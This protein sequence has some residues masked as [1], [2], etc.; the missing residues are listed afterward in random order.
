MLKQKQKALAELM[1]TQPTLSKAEYAAAIDISEKTVYNWQQLPEFT[2]YLHVCC[3]RRFR[4]FEK[5]AI[6]LL[7][8]N[9]EK[10]NQKAIEYLLNYI[11]Y[12]P[13]EQ[14]EIQMDAT[15]EIDYG[16]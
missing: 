7:F 11:G 16:E 5:E 3:E 9:A 2:E 4:S 15:I 13:T 6:D 10:G 1:A 8:K 12:K 14:Q